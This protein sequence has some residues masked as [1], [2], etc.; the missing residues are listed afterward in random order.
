M[1]IRYHLGWEDYFSA[2]EFF[3]EQHYSMPPERVVGGL[4]MLAGAL[5]FLLG[6]LN[7]QAVIP[8]SLGLIIFFGAAFFRRLAARRKWDKEEFYRAEHIV[9][10]SDEGVH[11][12]MGSIE[13]NLDWK[14]YQRFL[15]SPD[16]FLLIYGEDS[17]NLIPMRAF[18]DRKMIDEFRSLAIRKLGSETETN[19]V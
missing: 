13:S 10:F 1:T 4:L 5:W 14:Y 16:G 12:L 9:S 2:K 11:Y 7:L 8:L 17:F 6:N 18:E 3:R 19:R 15:E